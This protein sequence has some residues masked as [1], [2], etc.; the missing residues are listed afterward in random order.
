MNAI[1][2]YILT[3]VEKTMNNTNDTIPAGFISDILRDEEEY[4]KKTKQ[5]KKAKLEEVKA[6]SEQECDTSNLTLDEFLNEKL[7]NDASKEKPNSG[8]QPIASPKDEIFAILNTPP[9]YYVIQNIPEMLIPKFDNVDKI[10]FGSKLLQTN[11]MKPNMVSQPVKIH[12]MFIAL[13]IKPPIYED[14]LKSHKASVTDSSFAFNL[15]EEC[16]YRWFN[17]IPTEGKYYEFCALCDKF[18]ISLHMHYSP[19]KLLMAIENVKEY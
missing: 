4:L 11:H 5:S 8:A 12:K 13:L 7:N 1:L 2:F 3:I 14:I 17:N 16:Y 9:H 19:Q 15:E 18:G 10:Y 6:T